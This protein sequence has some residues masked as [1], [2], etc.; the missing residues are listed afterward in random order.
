MELIFSVQV[1][2]AIES[3]SFECPKGEYN[4]SKS[5]QSPSFSFYKKP[6]KKYFQLGTSEKASDG[7]D[8]GNDTTLVAISPS[9]RGND[10]GNRSD[11]DANSNDGVNGVHGHSNDPPFSKATTQ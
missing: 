9:D 2:A 10:E 5:S 1:A 8:H 11:H 7:S 6:L 4:L 3:V